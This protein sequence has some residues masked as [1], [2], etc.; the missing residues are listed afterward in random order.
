VGQ[1]LS[2]FRSFF[3]SHSV[4]KCDYDNAKK[5]LFR[6]FN[7]IFGKVG[8]YAPADV[9]VHMLQAKCLPALMYGLDACPVNSTETKS[10]E[11]AL[12][13]VYAKLFGTI[14]KSVLEDCCSA[15]GIKSLL[16]ITSTRK[17]VFF[18][19]YVASLNEVCSVFCS[20]AQIEIKMLTL[21]LGQK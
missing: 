18:N 20:D 11:F 4:F 2:V 19:R 6:S 7:A 10:L 14:S 16:S 17:L 9:I 21:K 12:F 15:F 1:N 5:T 8:R 3:K 13:R